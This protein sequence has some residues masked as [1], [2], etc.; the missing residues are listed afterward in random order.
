MY[1]DKSLTCRDCGEIF[2]FSAGEQEFYAA[3]GFENEP[4]RCPACRAARKRNSSSGRRPR[5]MFQA[6]CASCGNVA[7]VPFRPSSDRPVYCKDC[8]QSKSRW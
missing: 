6:V 3:K 5:E 2:V 4:V 8:F 1:Q 7:D